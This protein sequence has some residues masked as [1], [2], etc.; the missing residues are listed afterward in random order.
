MN[1]EIDFFF[2]SEAF[3]L[4]FSKVKRGNYW[5]EVKIGL[6]FSG[7]FSTLFS[8]FHFGSSVCIRSQFCIHVSSSQMAP[9]LY[10][11]SQ[12]SRASL[13]SALFEVHCHFAGSI[14]SCTDLFVFVVH[15]D[16]SLARS[17]S[18]LVLR[19]ELKCAYLDSLICSNDE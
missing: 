17:C 3:F 10:I 7:C 18:E 6:K 9:C 12:A 11:S 13:S 15:G 19:R 5:K 8:S 16:F 1:K 14:M 4:S 2:L